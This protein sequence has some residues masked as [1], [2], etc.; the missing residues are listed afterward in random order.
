MD[1]VGTDILSWEREVQDERV[2]TLISV[3][4]VR[5]HCAVFLMKGEE[6]VVKWFRL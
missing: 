2:E 1:D 6:K 3:K 5:W 4:G